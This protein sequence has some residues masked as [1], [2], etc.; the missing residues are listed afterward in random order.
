MTTIRFRSL[1][2]QRKHWKSFRSVNRSLPHQTNYRR[3]PGA[4]DRSTPATRQS[5]CG[6]LRDGWEIR[7]GKTGRDA[8]RVWAHV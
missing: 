8:G 6:R 2:L 4:V 3:D 7:G 5:G 1:L